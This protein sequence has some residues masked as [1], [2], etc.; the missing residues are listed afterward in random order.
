MILPFFIDPMQPA[1][2]DEAVIVEQAAYGDRWSRKDYEQELLQNKLAHYYVLRAN[3]TPPGLIGL[4]GFWLMVDEIHISTIAIHP[5]MRQLGLG[6]WLLIHLLEQGITLGAKVATLEVRRSNRA[7][8]ALYQKYHFEQ[9]GE[10]QR[11]Y[12]DG[13][14]A[15]I[16]T[17][18][19]LTT[20]VYDDFLAQHKRMLRRRLRALKA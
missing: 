2:I 10:R 11:Y 7:A 3:R 1:D 9:V 19:P 6:D 8:L 17:T 16:L 18:P 20:A 14:D 12:E 15:L 5:K 13:E 4:G